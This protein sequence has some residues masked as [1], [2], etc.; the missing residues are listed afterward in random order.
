MV[1]YIIN[2]SESTSS[3]L[4][5]GAALEARK[6]PLFAPRWAEAYQRDAPSY[7]HTHAPSYLHTHAPSYL[8]THAHAGTNEAEA[9]DDCLSIASI[10][11]EER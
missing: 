4:R 3:L 11:S 5:G 9:G 7:L 8:H 2:R 10:L 6:T 1:R